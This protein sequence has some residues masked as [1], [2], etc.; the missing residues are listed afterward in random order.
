[1]FQSTRISEEGGRV[2]AGHQ[3]GKRDKLTRE[4]RWELIDEEFEY[5]NKKLDRDVVAPD[6]IRTIIRTFRDKL[7]TEIFPGRTEVPKTLIFAKNDSHAEDIVNIAREEFGRG[8]E[9]CKKVTYRTTGEKPEDLIARF[10]NSYY[11][12]IAVTVDMISTG[13]DIRPLEC[14][15]FMR[16]VKSRVYFE[17]MRGRGTRTISP[18][19]FNAVT[20]DETHKTHF[21]IVDAVG[22]CES[23]KGDGGTLERK[24]GT[25]FD[26]LLEDVVTGIRDEDTLSTL[27]SRL[28]RL[29]RKLDEKDRVRIEEVSN[30][31]SLRDMANRLLD[32]IDLD[33]Q[34]SEAQVVFKTDNPTLA[35]I[36]EATRK[37]VDKACDPFDD[38]KLRKTIKEIKTKHEQIIDEANIDD[39]LSSGYDANAK[40]KA[41]ALVESFQQFIED[42]RDE[43]TALQI[44][45]SKPYGERHL[46]L[47][48][49]KE[50]AE[51]IEKPPLHITPSRLWQAYEQLN[52]SKVKGAG[53]KKLLTDIISLLRFATHESDVL[54]PFTE[55]VNERFER[56]LD[57]Q[58]RE[59]SEEQREWLEMIKNHISTSLGIE[60]D[61]FDYT[62]FQ[63]RG[64]LLRARQVFGDELDVIMD[65]LNGAL[66]V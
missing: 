12:R 31:L 15:L 60:E 47:K 32:A 4:Q 53:A 58:G 1:M 64:G 40:E 2:E 29:D 54:E 57:Q 65:E 37:L 21:V 48:Q 39:V 44:F 10:R 56:W 25:S 52:R 7:F 17:Q 61:D 8:N 34:K 18:T 33:A 38:P 42:N 22:V 45:Y 63:E 26:K 30:G 14:L 62:P 9:F 28:A 59:F 41:H 24:K 66:A 43:I 49:I 13:T 55:T 50:L 19:E 3:I 11:P 36:E 35:Q 5:N 46:T 27:A 23:E 6:Q 51:A 20:P 16:D